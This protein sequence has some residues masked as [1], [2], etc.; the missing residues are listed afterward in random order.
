MD[1][2]TLFKVIELPTVFEPSA[3]YFVPDPIAGYLQVHLSNQ[4]GDAV[5]RTVSPADV[6]T[7]ATAAAEAV[8]VAQATSVSKKYPF[9]A[10]LKLTVA[11]GLNTTDYMFS[12][13]NAAGQRVYAP[14]TPLNANTFEINFTEPEE[15]VLMVTY[16]LN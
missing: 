16:F 5:L 3:A 4:A 7:I 10:T 13:I 11:H 9:A 6:E 15:G 8:V 1:A 2:L 12:I 14:D